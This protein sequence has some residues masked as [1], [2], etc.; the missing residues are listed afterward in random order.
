MQDKEILSFYFQMTCAGYLRGH[1]G[2]RQ[3][4]VGGAVVP[5]CYVDHLLLLYLE[6]G[7]VHREGIYIDRKNCLK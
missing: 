5:N 2:D 6:N 4:Q 1:R 3:H 7:Q